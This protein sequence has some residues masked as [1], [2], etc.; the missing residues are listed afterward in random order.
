MTKEDILIIPNETKI[1]ERL[2]ITKE[3]IVIG[4]N[5]SIEYGLKTPGSII[6]GDRVSIMGNIETKDIT[7]GLWSFVEGNILCNGDAF[8]GEKSEI[9]GHLNVENNLDIGKDVNIEEGFEVNGWITIRN[10]I[11][12]FVYFLIFLSHLIRTEETEKIEEILEETFNEENNEKTSKE[13][14]VLPKNINFSSEVATSGDIL[15]GERCR[16]VGNIRG[17]EIKIGK[18]TTLFGGIKASEDVHLNKD[19]II[20]GNVDSD[21][22]I[23][24]KKNCNVLGDVKGKR[25]K[26]H[27]KAH[28]NGT[29]HAVDWVEILPKKDVT[30]ENKIKDL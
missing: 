16:F 9:K 1:E 19:S 26:L 3:D 5:S 29:I 8:I 27:K 30:Q 10:P 24:I 12:I 13:A 14:M 21:E 28:V 20:H 4:S 6:A 23:E 18:E 17:N 25:I 7:L 2:I 15:I 11:P 22:D